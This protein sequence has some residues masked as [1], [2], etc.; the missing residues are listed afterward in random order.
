[1][2]F[3]KNKETEFVKTKNLTIIFIKQYCNKFDIKQ[4]GLICLN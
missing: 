2:S 3:V 4:K 1:M